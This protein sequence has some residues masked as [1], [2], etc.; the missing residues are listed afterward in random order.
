MLWANTIFLLGACFTFHQRLPV[1][2]V[3]LQKN[4]W[5]RQCAPPSSWKDRCNVNVMYRSTGLMPFVCLRLGSEAKLS[6]SFCSYSKANRQLNMH[7]SRWVSSYY[8]CLLVLFFFPDHSHWKSTEHWPSLCWPTCILAVTMTCYLFLV[9]LRNS[10]IFSIAIKILKYL[11]LDFKFVAVL[12][13]NLQI[14]NYNQYL[15]MHWSF[16][17]TGV[18]LLPFYCI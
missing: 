2:M 14:F 5:M 17:A 7:Y 6:R 13:F 12:Y 11:N 3:F 16:L 18:V 1:I 8:R 9:S 4:R 15:I 10:C